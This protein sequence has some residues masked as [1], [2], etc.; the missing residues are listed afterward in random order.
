MEEIFSRRD[1]SPL[2]KVD[3]TLPP[4]E[5]EFYGLKGAKVGV[6]EVINH[7]TI[8]N[9]ELHAAK[10]SLHYKD[11]FLLAFSKEDLVKEVVSE[12]IFLARNSKDYIWKQNKWQGVVHDK[13]TFDLVS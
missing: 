8:N 5:D 13:L 11:P 9:L 12:L 4:R 7:E 1:P 10:S 6:V 3:W 2:P